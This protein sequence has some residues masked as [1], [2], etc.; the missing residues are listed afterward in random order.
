MLFMVKPVAVIVVSFNRQ[1][2]SAG[3]VGFP[4]NMKRKTAAG[5]RRDAAKTAARLEAEGYAVE[6]KDYTHG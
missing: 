2:Y 6:V 3:V 1:R 5:A 4:A